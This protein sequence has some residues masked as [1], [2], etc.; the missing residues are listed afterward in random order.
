MKTA[1]ILTVALAATPPWRSQRHQLTLERPPAVRAPHPDILASPVGADAFVGELTRGN[2]RNSDVISQVERLSSN[3][4][5][6]LR[7]DWFG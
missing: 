2:I 4:T 6:K 3:E 5:R 1:I 7:Q